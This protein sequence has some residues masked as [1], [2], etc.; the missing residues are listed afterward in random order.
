MVSWTTTNTHTLVTKVLR[1]NENLCPH[2]PSHTLANSTSYTMY[3]YFDISWKQITIIIYLHTKYSLISWTFQAFC[4]KSG[5]WSGSYVDQYGFNFLFKAQL[6]F[7]YDAVY[8]NG[9]DSSGSYIINGSHDPSSGIITFRKRYKCNPCSATTFWGNLADGGSS[10][11][12]IYTSQGGVDFG[13]F[14][15]SLSTWQAIDRAASLVI[16]IVFQ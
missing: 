1:I 16:E 14:K 9:C 12:G 2:I 4:G 6:T 3:F 11:C 13:A 8:G 7:R 10:A 5:I 15:L